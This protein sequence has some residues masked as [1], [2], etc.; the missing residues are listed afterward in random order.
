MCG[1]RWMS[2]LRRC[3]TSPPHADQPNKSDDDVPDRLL[4][5][6]QIIQDLPP[7]WFR[8]RVERI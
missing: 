6:C 3:S 8:H 7:S 4:L 2:H 1:R 5:Q